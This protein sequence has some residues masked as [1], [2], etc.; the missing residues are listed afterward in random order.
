M[1]NDLWE[2]FLKNG[3][4]ESYMKYKEVEKLKKEGTLADE[5]DKSKRDS[6][7][8]NNIQG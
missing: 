1:Y 7:K 3:K 5:T 6:N 2:E 8:R 4:V